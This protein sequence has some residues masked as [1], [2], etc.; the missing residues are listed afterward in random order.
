MGNVFDNH[1]ETIT[2]HSK[3]SAVFKIPFQ[4]QKNAYEMCSKQIQQYKGDFQ[5]VECVRQNFKIS[6][7]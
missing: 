5:E 4:V 6:V 2:Y 3:Y 7:R 1:R